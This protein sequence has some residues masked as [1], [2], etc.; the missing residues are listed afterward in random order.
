MKLKPL[1]WVGSSKSDVLQFP[2]EVRRLVGYAL[3]LAQSQTQ[4][5]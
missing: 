4:R 2:D 5:Y 3:Y 1:K